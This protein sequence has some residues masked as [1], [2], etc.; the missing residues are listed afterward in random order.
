MKLNP[1]WYVTLHLPKRVSSINQQVLARMRRKGNIF[2]LLVGMQTGAATLENS[3][4]VIQKIKNGFAF[5]P[6][7]PT[8]GNVS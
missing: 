6:R 3:M 4:E 1:Q 2:A 7:D 8:S 5:W